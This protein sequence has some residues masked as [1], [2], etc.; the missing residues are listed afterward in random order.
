MLT[1]IRIFNV[2]AAFFV[3]HFEKSQGPKNSKLK[4]ENKNYEKFE[5]KLSKSTSKWQ[6]FKR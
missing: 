1:G 3:R 5:K 4:T 6:N 2:L